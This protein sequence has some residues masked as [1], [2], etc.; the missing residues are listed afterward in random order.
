MLLIERE[1]ASFSPELLSNGI[2]RDTEPWN[3]DVDVVDASS[4]IYLS[5]TLF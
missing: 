3:V 5:N 1:T 2:C 4:L